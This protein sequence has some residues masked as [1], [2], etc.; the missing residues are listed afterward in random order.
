[1]DYKKKLDDLIIEMDTRGGSDLHFNCGLPPSVRVDGELCF[2][3]TSGILS[4]TDIESFLSVLLTQKA[5]Q[6]FKLSHDL[7]FAYISSN[8]VRL[9]GNAYIEKGHPAIAL[10][11]VPK[12]FV[13]HCVLPP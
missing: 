9:R 11:R 5:G 6:D 10:R 1:M 13:L 12:V 7:D 4:A 2:L 8:A 3:E